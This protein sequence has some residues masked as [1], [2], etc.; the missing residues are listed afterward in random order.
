MTGRRLL[1]AGVLLRRPGRPTALVCRV[2]CR[3]V[4]QGVVAL[5]GRRH[6]RGGVGV[7][8][9]S[10]R[11]LPGLLPVGCTLE[12]GAPALAVVVP[13]ARFAPRE[14]RLSTMPLALLLRHLPASA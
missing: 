7:A 8:T 12:V 14:R 4:L 1:W 6:S 13:M 2:R 3:G 11:P 5:V 9:A 10:C